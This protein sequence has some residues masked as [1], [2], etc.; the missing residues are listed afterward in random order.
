MKPSAPRDQALLQFAVIARS[1]CELVETADESRAAEILHEIHVMLARLYLGALLLPHPF[2]LMRDDDVGG[3][4]EDDAAGV[5]AGSEAD[6]SS[7]KKVI[8]RLGGI[9][10]ERDSYREVFNPYAPE[11]DAEVRGSLSDDVADIHRHLRKGL[12]HWNA[13]AFGEALFE[14]RFGFESH[15]SE[16]AS[17]AIRALFARS[18]WYDMGWPQRD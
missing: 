7:Y 3:N 6:R 10:G 8:H 11:T 4:D 13:G 9:F 16:H 12:D 15:W 18:A 5:V 1:F 2:A 17:G 14:W